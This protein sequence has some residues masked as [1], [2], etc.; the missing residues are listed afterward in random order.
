MNPSMRLYLHD[1]A[2]FKVLIFYLMATDELV[3]SIVGGIVSLV[4]D[5]NRVIACLGHVE[6]SAVVDTSLANQK[7]IKMVYF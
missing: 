7:V 3:R 5:T 1:I 6:Y 4:E 2:W